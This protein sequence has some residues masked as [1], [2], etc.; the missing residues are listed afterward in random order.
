MFHPIREGVRGR[1]IACMQNVGSTEKT[2]RVCNKIALECDA[3]SWDVI[4]S[5]TNCEMWAKSI[6][7]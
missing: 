7:H 3:I 5:E 1:C 4:V 6:R 2:F